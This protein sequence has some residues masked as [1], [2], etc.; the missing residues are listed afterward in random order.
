MQER[1]TRLWYDDPS[2]RSSLLGPLSWIYGRVGAL[3]TRAYAAGW[4]H[5]QR[6]GRPVII[7]GNLTVG[8][9]GK[10]P[11]VAWLAEQLTGTG[12]RVGIVSRGYGRRFRSPHLV[13]PDSDWREVGDEPLLLRRRTGCLTMVGRDRVAAAQ[14]LVAR[15]VN[16]IVA[17]DG[18]Q[19]LRLARECEIV[20]VDGSRGFGNGRL[21]PAGPLREPVERLCRSDVAIVNGSR[22]HRSLAP[23]LRPSPPLVLSMST[24]AGDACP[25]AADRAARPLESFRGQQVHAVA[26]IGNPSRF[27]R[28]L[29]ARGIEV[30]E[31][32]FA[33]HHPFSARELEFPDALEVLMTEKDAVKC[34]GFAN[35]RLWYVPIRARFGETHERELL[36]CVL[37]RTGLAGSAQRPGR[38]A[39]REV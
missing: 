36:Q 3:R 26:G 33:D 25:V 21:L 20:V 1:L 7:V 32:R 4:L 29:R 9:T 8:G 22:E 27:F 34:R 6:A 24:V 38:T 10:T 31:H 16:V 28:D 30:V 35:P 2:S 15:G 19:H 39:A 14:A 17:D 12:L 13:E 18:L 37:R 11:V 23:D 5:T